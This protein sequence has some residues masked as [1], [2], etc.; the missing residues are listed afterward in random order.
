MPSTSEAIAHTAPLRSESSDGFLIRARDLRVG[1]GQHEIIPGINLQIPPGKI[2]TIIGPNGCGKSTL[3]KALSRLMPFEGEVTLGGRSLKE[4]PRRDL[5]RHI[6]VLPQSPTAPEGIL[7]ADLVSRGR[8]PHQSWFNQWSRSD[9]GVV[10]IAMKASGIAALADRPLD[11]LSGGQRQRAWIA[12]VLAQETDILML[13]EPTTFLDLS[14]SVDVLNT[15]VYLRDQLSRTIVMVLHDINLAA[16][17][18]DHLLVMKDGEIL[19]VGAPKDIISSELLHEVFA[20]EAEVIE[21][22]VNGAPV[23]LPL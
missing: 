8:H 14:H 2:T 16:R 9:E 21:S 15:V 13:D 17:Y 5:A 23:V 12:M 6:G 11:S 19:A 10:E 3:L 4:Y 7:V 18:S 20:L 1:Y 22:P